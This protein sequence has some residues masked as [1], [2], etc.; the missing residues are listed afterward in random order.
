[1]EI[2]K[3][4]VRKDKAEAIRPAQTGIRKVTGGQVKVDSR[5]TIAANAKVK[6]KAAAVTVGPNN[7]TA[8]LRQATIMAAETAEASGKDKVKVKAKGKGKVREEETTTIMA[9]ETKEV[10][11]ITAT[12]PITEITAAVRAD[13]AKAVL[14]SPNVRRSTIR[15]R[16]LSSAAR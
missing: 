6:V 14:N 11:M 7:K 9:A 13:A 10:M 2:I 5:V 8:A 3:T 15:R 16:R 4:L 12:A 1:M